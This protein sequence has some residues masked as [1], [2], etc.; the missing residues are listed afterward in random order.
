MIAGAISW[1]NEFAAGPAT[2]GATAIV[3]RIDDRPPYS[4]S[5][6]SLMRLF[7]YPVFQYQDPK[8]F[9]RELKGKGCLPGHFA[10]GNTVQ[11]GETG[12]RTVVLDWWFRAQEHVILFCFGLGVFTLGAFAFHHLG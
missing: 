1:Y 7:D 4:G 12:S 9:N 10:I 5:K 3:V 8:G 2:P 11:L 6:P